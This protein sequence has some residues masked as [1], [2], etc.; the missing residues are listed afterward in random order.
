MRRGRGWGG[1]SAPESPPPAVGPQPRPGPSLR[2][3]RRVR[4]RRR[5]GDRRR[6]GTWGGAAGRDGRT[7]AGSGGSAAGRSEWLQSGPCPPILLPRRKCAARAPRVRLVPLCVGV[8]VRVLAAVCRSERLWVGARMLF[9]SCFS[10]C[11][12]EACPCL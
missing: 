1:P 10:L 2:P 8:R 7:G 5:R 12:R 3:V 11:P 4:R 6:R 9:K